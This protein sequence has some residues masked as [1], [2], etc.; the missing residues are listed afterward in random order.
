MGLEVTALNKSN[1]NHKCEK[2]E[3]EMSTIKFT[4]GGTIVNAKFASDRL[5]KPNYSCGFVGNASDYTTAGSHH[6]KK[7]NVLNM[8]TWSKYRTEK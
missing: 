2:S 5:S 1:I 6:D 4:L 8:W 7:K 3:K